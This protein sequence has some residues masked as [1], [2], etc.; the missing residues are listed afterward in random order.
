M[1]C[2][3]AWIEWSISYKDPCIKPYD[4]EAVDKI[5]R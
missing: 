5:G 2:S 3:K 1:S 4:Q